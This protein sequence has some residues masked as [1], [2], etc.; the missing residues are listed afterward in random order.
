MNK[1]KNKKAAK[2]S[3]KL[4]RNIIK[5]S[6]DASAWSFSL[7]LF[8]GE[9]TIETFLK[10]SYYAD[11]PSGNFDVLQPDKLKKKK[12][13]KNTIKQSIR[14]LQKQGFVEKNGN[15][16]SITEKGKKLV[17]YVLRRKKT[18]KQKWDKKYR[19]VIFDIPEKIRKERDWLRSELYLLNYKQLQKSVF[20]SKFP[21]TADLIKE[22]KKRKMGN[23]VN[24]LLVDR[25]YDM[26]DE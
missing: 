4:A 15:T 9:A 11:L 14:R 17:N 1:N 2:Y 22:I 12:F 25:V 10:P 13:E 18:L 24:Y 20:V 16:Y 7:L 26:K 5:G 8:L 3:K 19:V 23:Y 6:L 21:L